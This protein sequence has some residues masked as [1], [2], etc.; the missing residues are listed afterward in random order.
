MSENFSHQE[1]KDETKA[2]C[3]SAKRPALAN[4]K[5]K[6]RFSQSS[7]AGFPEVK[8]KSKQ[9]N[10]DAK[11][12][13]ESKY[14]RVAVTP[15]ATAALPLGCRSPLYRVAKPTMKRTVVLH[16]FRSSRTL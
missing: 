13:N 15:A 12:K 2:D 1:V 3:L 6:W 16:S 9:V 5:C 11:S 10:A 7:V 8:G 4:V 14:D